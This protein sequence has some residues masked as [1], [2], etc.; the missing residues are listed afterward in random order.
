MVVHRRTKLLLVAVRSFRAR[1]WAVGGVPHF[2]QVLNCIMSAGA[3]ERLL[4]INRRQ[5]YSGSMIEREIHGM[6][7]NLV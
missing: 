3:E 7:F 4:F 5:Y 6:A 2:W 1:R